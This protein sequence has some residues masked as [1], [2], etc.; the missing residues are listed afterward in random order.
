VRLLPPL[1]IDRAQADEA[2]ARLRAVLTAGT[3]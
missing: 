2:I 3:G 1:T